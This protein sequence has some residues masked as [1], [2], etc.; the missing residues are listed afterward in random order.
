VLLWHCS[1]PAS[2]MNHF[3]LNL[4]SN[5]KGK[6]PS[7]DQEI[8][9]PVRSPTMPSP[10]PS[11]RFLATPQH[12]NRSSRRNSTALSTYFPGSSSDEL[13]I[14]KADVV[15]NW[16]H[17]KQTQ[18]M[19]TTGAPGQGVILKQS[20]DVFVACPAELSHVRGHLFDAV[21]KLNV[22]VRRTVS[23]NIRQPA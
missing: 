2:E 1:L 20:R 7:P 23:S 11:P 4:R 18:N 6:S 12:S 5:G 10:L 16:L 21:R 9:I 14:I 19:W 13:A 15:A 8:E 22:R 3:R 17:S